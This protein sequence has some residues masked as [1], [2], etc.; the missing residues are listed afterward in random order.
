MN[1]NVGEQVNSVIN[2][3]CDKLGIAADKIYPVLIKQA[4]IDGIMGIIWFVISLAIAITGFIVGVKAL[5]NPEEND[6]YAALTNWTA[7]TH[8]RIWFGFALT[9]IFTI[10]AANSIN[11]VI[12]ALGNPEWYV[13]QIILNQVK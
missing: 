8:V 11:T 5:K 7:W 6:D 3:L 10:I 12:T 2:N 13:L 9:L 4:H 1:N